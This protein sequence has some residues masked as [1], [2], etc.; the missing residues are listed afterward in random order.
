[1][2]W[3]IQEDSDRNLLITD[4]EG[5]RVAA[6]IK[7][8]GSDENAIYSIHLS[9]LSVDWFAAVLIIIALKRLLTYPWKERE[10][11]L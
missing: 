11:L 9:G 10:T 3:I 2:N 7:R 1:M 6:T 4:L 5:S 8:Y